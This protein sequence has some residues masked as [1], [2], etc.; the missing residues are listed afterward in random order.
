MAMDGF[1]LKKTGTLIAVMAPHNSY[2]QDDWVRWGSSD[3][4]TSSNFKGMEI[5]GGIGLGW[6]AN[7]IAQLFFVRANHKEYPD[8]VRNQTGNRFRVDANIKF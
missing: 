1:G 3:Q 4:A 7:I 8:S 2:A 6:N 5:R